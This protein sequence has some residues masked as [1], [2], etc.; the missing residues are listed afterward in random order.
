MID[1]EDEVVR[2]TRS[3]KQFLRVTFPNG[4]S[5]CYKNITE[6][7][8][9]VLIEIG[10]DKFR[11]IKLE[12]CHLPMLSKEIYKGLEKWMR[13][14]CDGWYLNT[15]T[16]TDQKYRQLQII[17]NEFDLGLKVEMGD[18]EDLNPITKPDKERKS[19]SKDKLLVTFPDGEFVANGSAMDTY[20]ETIWEIGIDEIKRKGLSFRDHELITFAKQNKY[21]VQVDTDR[22]LYV[23]NT[24]ADKVKVLRVIAAMLHIKLEVTII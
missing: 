7:M 2:R 23:P 1:E 19:K 17:N 11:K 12:V 16:V 10:S 13:P 22:W 21:Q 6:T 5:I 4:K 20:I 3:K 15:Q 14:V 8:I 18:A 24:T 9:D